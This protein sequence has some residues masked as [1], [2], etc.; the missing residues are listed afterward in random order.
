MRR[1]D[2]K[3]RSSGPDNILP[4][5]RTAETNIQEVGHTA[6]TL[7][8]T[9]QRA[10]GAN[11]TGC[12]LEYVQTNNPKPSSVSEQRSLQS[13]SGRKPAGLEFQWGKHRRQ[14]DAG[15]SDDRS[16]LPLP[17]RGGK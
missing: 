5:I 3:W 16:D 14:C 7:H 8:A 13:R 17:L 1:T 9:I 4:D 10:G 6:A 2:R 15:R 11:I 12:K